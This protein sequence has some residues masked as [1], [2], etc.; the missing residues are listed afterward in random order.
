LLFVWIG[1]V[2]ARL[3]LNRH[4]A[5]K[6]EE[7]WN[8]SG[9]GVTNRISIYR[10]VARPGYYRVGDT[11]FTV[12]PHDDTE[13]KPE[14]FLVRLTH[15]ENFDQIL[16][17][18]KSYCTVW[19]DRHLPTKNKV[20]IWRVVCPDNFV[21]LGHVATSGSV[22]LPGDVYCV[23][24]TYTTVG[25][26]RDW[27]AIWDE[28]EVG[29]KQ[30]KIA[31]IA[32][33]NTLQSNMLTI[34]AVGVTDKGYF[35]S[36]PNFLL[37]SKV[38]PSRDKPVKAIRLFNFN[39]FNKTKDQKVLEDK[40]NVF[41]DLFSNTFYN[42]LA[43]SDNTTVK[44]NE[45]ISFVLTN[46][47]CAIIPGVKVTVDVKVPILKKG[48]LSEEYSTVKLGN[49]IC[50][51]N[52]VVP[53]VLNFAEKNIKTPAKSL[54]SISVV[55]KRFFSTITFSGK[56]TKEF[57]VADPETKSING[58]EYSTSLSAFTITKSP[59]PSSKKEE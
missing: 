7:I 5:D 37:T 19:N 18:P 24:S 22:P 57:Y 41:S 51:D 36:P 52:V 45:T 11:A 43:R 1:V 47:D 38:H 4:P 49:Y 32:T 14:G 15:P 59:S 46:D 48:N 28:K 9:S 17:L 29:T 25:I 44:F 35:S 8:D 34:N 30:K 50:G 21:A 6:L 58:E 39:N 31:I 3:E 13:R 53:H 54:Y 2:S 56:I 23:N 26:L 20:Q 40:V 16:K 27:D 55:G 33:A 12:K 42:P 10:S